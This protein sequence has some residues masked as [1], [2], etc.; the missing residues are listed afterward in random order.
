MEP[1][2]TKDPKVLAWLGTVSLPLLLQPF[3]SGPQHHNKQESPGPPRG[4][5]HADTSYVTGIL[6]RPP[7]PAVQQLVLPGDERIQRDF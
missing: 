6:Q 4:S 3:Y 5:Q 7:V 2:L 1:R